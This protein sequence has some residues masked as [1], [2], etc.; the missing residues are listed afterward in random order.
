VIAW[1][2]HGSLGNGLEAYHAVIIGGATAWNIWDACYELMARRRYRFHPASWWRR[3]AKVEM[4][5]RQLAQGMQQDKDS[6]DI[7]NGGK[8]KMMDPPEI[9]TS[10]ALDRAQSL[11]SILNISASKAVPILV[12]RK[13]LS[14]SRSCRSL[15]SVSTCTSCVDVRYECSKVPRP[16]RAR[17]ERPSPIRCANAF[18]ALRA[19]AFHHD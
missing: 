18:S 12:I 1:S 3:T 8:G 4:Q 7:G 10:R 9:L 2:C 11:T 6:K 19:L 13:P 5:M 14:S 15:C 17:L 16:I